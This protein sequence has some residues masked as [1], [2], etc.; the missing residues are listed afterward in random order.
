MNRIVAAEAFAAL[1]HEVRLNAWHLLL[2]AGQRGLSAAGLAS[3]LSV[4]L[5]TLYFHVRKL[6]NAGLVSGSG[7]R[8]ETFIARVAPV[9]ELASYLEANLVNRERGLRP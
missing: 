9:R 1:G 2:D 6:C 7:D 4:N 8:P 3:A 5:A